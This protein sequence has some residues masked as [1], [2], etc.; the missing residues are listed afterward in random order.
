MVSAANLSMARTACASRK[1]PCP[2]YT[3]LRSVAGQ[4]ATSF[5]GNSKMMRSILHGV[6]AGER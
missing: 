3:S 1:A 6:D 2:A 5:A 4:A